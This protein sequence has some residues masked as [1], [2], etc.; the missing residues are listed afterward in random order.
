MTFLRDLLPA[1]ARK[2]VYNVLGSL[3]G[4]ELALDL[5]GW[6]V[7]PTELQSK[8]VIVAGALGFALAGANTNRPD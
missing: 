1:R 4:C 6:G 8:I 7:V 3:M 2:A 5:V